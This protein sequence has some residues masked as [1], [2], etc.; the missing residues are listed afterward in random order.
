MAR[1]VSVEFSKVLQDA[2][3]APEDGLQGVPAADIANMTATAG[4]LQ[5]HPVVEII[6]NG[7]GALRQ[8]RVVSGLQ[9]QGGY[10]DVLEKRLAAGLLIVI[11]NACKA[12]QGCCNGVVKFPEGA[13]F[14]EAVCLKWHGMCCC[15]CFH[16]FAKLLQQVLL[17]DA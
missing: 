14:F 5:S 6:F 1:F 15:F 12:M 3:F 17:I 7:E 8:K 16:G 4:K 10:R 2:L 13:Q 11:V 9:H